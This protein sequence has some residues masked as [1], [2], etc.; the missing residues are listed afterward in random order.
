MKILTRFQLRLIVFISRDVDLQKYHPQPQDLTHYIMRT[1][2]YPLSLG[3]FS[4]VWK[5]KLDSF[6]RN[7]IKMPPQDVAVKALRVLSR[8][9]KDMKQLIKKLRQEVFLWQQLKHSHILPLYGTTDRFGTIPALVCPWMENGSLQQYLKIMW[10]EQFPPEM[11]RLFRLLSQVVLG[12]QYLHFKNIIHGDL[13]PFNVLIDENENALLA[14][15]GLSRLLGD[16]ETSFFDSHGPGAIRWAAPEITPLDPE[17]PDEEISKPNKA[18]DIYSFGCIMMQVLSGQSPYFDISETC[19]PVAKFKGTPPTR[20]PGIA[21]V[22]WCYIERCLSPRVGTRPLV[23][24][25]LEY[26]KAEC[27]RQKLASRAGRSRQ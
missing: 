21:D 8:N 20:P 7:G 10:D 27:D 13:M 26:I 18:S 6:P 15:F 24:E 9:P 3:G 1:E 23:D 4:D 22:H 14:D 19:I 25:V 16:H 11:H 12:L 5:C 17:K 2:N